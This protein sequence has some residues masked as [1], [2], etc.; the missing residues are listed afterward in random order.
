MPANSQPGFGCFVDR[1]QLAY[2][3]RW[4][5]YCRHMA[6]VGMNTFAFYPKSDADLIDQIETGITSG[7]L[8]K[9]VPVVLVSNM[10]PPPGVHGNEDEWAALPE[11]VTAARAKAAHGRQWPEVI[12]YG[13]DEP[14]K[15][16]QCIAWSCSY[17]HGKAAALTA[18]CVPTVKD[19]LPLLD[20]IL[21]HASPGVLTAENVKATLAEGVYFGVYNIGLRRASPKLM[22]YWRGVW[23]YQAGCMVNLLWWYPTFIWDRPQGP[24]SRQNLVGYAQGAAD[25]ARLRETRPKL[26]PVDWDFWPGICNG[27]PEE[28]AAWKADWIANGRT[29]RVPDVLPA[30]GR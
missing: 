27:T 17:R 28:R 29:C 13:T 24:V 21:I 8:R 12:L 10:P 16:E 9:N 7:L 18:I 3:E 20:G 25:F 1:W 15:A 30:G 23:S 11:R 26:P 4:D 5:R 19:F 2:P 22:R 6:S 14:V